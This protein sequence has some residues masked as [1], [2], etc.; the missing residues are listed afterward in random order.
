MRQRTRP[1][2]AR[3]RSARLPFNLLITGE[4]GTGKTLAGRKIHRRSSEEYRNIV[5]DLS[6]KFLS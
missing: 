4:T 2:V 1:T 5:Y 6:G 3:R